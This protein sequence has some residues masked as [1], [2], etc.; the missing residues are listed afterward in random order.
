MSGEC[1]RPAKPSGSLDDIAEGAPERAALT[2]LARHPLVRGGRTRDADGPGADAIQINVGPAP[3]SG[4]QQRLLLEPISG[5]RSAGASSAESNLFARSKAPVGRTNQEAAQYRVD[6]S[7]SP[8]VESRD[9]AARRI[10][11]VVQGVCFKC[12]AHGGVAPRNLALV[13][14]LIYRFSSLISVVSALLNAPAE[15]GS[16]RLPQFIAVLRINLP[17]GCSGHQRPG[18][19]MARPGLGGSSVLLKVR[20][21]RGI[22]L[23]LWPPPAL[24]SR[25]SDA[26]ARRIGA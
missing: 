10:V 25:S 24:N 16:S 26:Q 9:L 20:C 2:L 12:F 3:R 8:N 13:S 11:P 19:P 7:K 15:R 21:S 4:G 1:G 5:D 22:A 6:V 17:C 18:L 23:L 14:S